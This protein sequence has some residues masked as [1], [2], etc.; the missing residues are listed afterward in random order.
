[1]NVYGLHKKADLSMC[2]TYAKNCY[3]KNMTAETLCLAC[4]FLFLIIKP[5]LWVPM[6]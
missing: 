4:L 2:T 3:K 6:L 5:N 1:M